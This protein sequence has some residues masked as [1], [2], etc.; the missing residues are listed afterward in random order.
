MESAPIDEKMSDSY[1]R[2]SQITDWLAI[3]ATVGMAALAVSD[4]N[5][6]RWLIPLWLAMMVVKIIEPFLFAAWW[7]RQK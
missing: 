1:R 5:R 6:V 2:P 3:M 7:V 4:P